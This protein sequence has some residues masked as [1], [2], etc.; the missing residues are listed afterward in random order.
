ME[1]GS[2]V[3]EDKD[4]W[5]QCKIPFYGKKVD[6]IIKPRIKDRSRQE[7]KYFHGVVCKMIAEEMGIAPQEAKDFLKKMFL[8]EEVK[9]PE[10]FRYERTIST[11]ELDD[12]KNVFFAVLRIT[13][14]YNK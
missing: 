10:G 11:T 3:I 7:E 5:E 13:V 9:S 6:I 14:F 2:I 1:G 8:R 12:K 4:R